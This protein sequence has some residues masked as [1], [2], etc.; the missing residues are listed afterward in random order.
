MKKLIIFGLLF[1]FLSQPIFASDKN[2]T[3]LSIS[4]AVYADLAIR[5]YLDNVSIYHT[6]GKTSDDIRL[7]ETRHWIPAST[8]KTFA[9]MYAYKLMSE[10]KLHTYDTILIEPKN[11]VSTELVTDEL[12]ALLDGD[13]VTADRLIKQMITQSDNTAFNVLLDVLG[14]D[15]I[16]KYIQSLGLTHSNVGSKLNLDTSQEQYEFDAPGYGINTTTAEDY[17]RAFSLIQKNKIPGAKELLAI[18]KDQKINNMIPLLL[19]KDVS[20]AHKTGDLDPLYHDGGIC[21]DKKQSYVLAIFTNAGDTNLLAHLS[22]LIYTKNFNLVGETLEKKS[23]GQGSQENHPLDALVMNPPISYVLAASTFSNF[24]E[25]PITAADLGVTAKDLSLVIKDKDLPRVLIPADSPLHVFSDAWQTLKKGV[26]LFPK[27]RRNVDLETARLRLAETKDLIKRGKEKQARVVLQS[28]QQGLST[29]AKDA[30]IAN[31]SSAQNT[32]NAVSETRFAILADRLKQAKD[33]EKLTLIKE[34]ASQAKATLQ[35]IQ[36]NIPHATNA[37]NPSQKPLIGEVIKMTSNDI[38]VKT[39]GGQELTISI[40]NTS[41]IVKEKGVASNLSQTSPGIKEVPSASPTPASSL[42]SL[43][44]GTTVAL[45]G[46]TTNNIFSP[47][48]I[49]KNIPKE[50]AAPQPVTVAKVDTKHNTMVVVENGIYTQVN[51][52][53]GTSIKGANTN[54]PLKE[55]KS[56][57]IV[58]VHGEPLSTIAPKNTQP[59][60]TQALPKTSV[61]PNVKTIVPSQL[62]SNF[63]QPSQIPSKEKTT[64]LLTPSSVNPLPVSTTRK[65][66]PQQS[67]PPSQGQ[68]TQPQPKVIQGT[69]IKLIEKKENAIKPPAPITSQPKKEQKPQQNAPQ[70]QQKK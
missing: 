57:D 48:F 9:A 21:Q 51:I 2:I 49:L 11:A 52:N 17:A 7:N 54:I 33:N 66:A 47:T 1:L 42:N 38:T 6:D 50:L 65:V 69:S 12:P 59:S 60:P 62:P 16:T 27:A 53:K 67:L 55:I 14:R 44:V 31:D 35:N 28:L 19:P 61:A 23:L 36:P 43:A 30:A 37:T 45:F 26:V 29:V 58:I 25:Q 64:P 22:E 20:C 34:I 68:T 24:P 3:T 18:L 39:A 5:N 10:G 32:I 41:V 63:P 56:G 8:V 15:N 70:Q 13:S 40:N 4:D 46:S